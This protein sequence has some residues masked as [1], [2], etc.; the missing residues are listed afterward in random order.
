MRVALDKDAAHAAIAQAVEAILVNVGEDPTREGLLKTPERVAQR[1]PIELLEGYTIDPVALVNGAFFETEYN[2][3]VIVKDIEFYSMCEHH[4]LPFLA[5]YS[6]AYIPEGQVLGLSKIPRIVEMSRAAPAIAGKDDA[7]K[8]PDFIQELLH[9]RGVAVI[10]T[11]QRMCSMMRGV[12]QS[13]A[14]MVTQVL[15]GAFQNSEVRG[16]LNERLEANY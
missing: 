14:K 4:M 8:S 3:M 12:N 9:P 7:G 1:V 10:V 13:E 6:V 11:G 16:Q 5:R 15:Y 2:D